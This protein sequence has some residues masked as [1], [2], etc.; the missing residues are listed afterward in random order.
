MVH[1]FPALALALAAALGCADGPPAPPAE[2]PA[3]PPAAE[4]PA[5]P[6]ALLLAG[7]DG[8]ERRWTEADLRAALGEPRI[9]EVDSPVY[10]K[11][12]RYRGYPLADVLAAAG[13]D[14]RWR[15]VLAFRC[16]DGFTPTLDAD[17]VG[18]LALFLAVGQP[19]LPG[20]ARWEPLGQTSPAPFYVVGPDKA[21][22]DRL[23]WP[24]Q[25]ESIRA[26]D[27][28]AAHPAAHPRGAPP[29]SAAMR[30]FARFRS[31][32]FGC[33]SINLEGGV[34]GPELNAPVSVLDYW[35]RPM[36][37][38][39]LA[40]PASVRARSKM[41]ALGLSPADIADILAYLAHMRDLGPPPAR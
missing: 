22:Y 1:R 15:G 35:Q 33:H 21:S 11:R 23:P 10:H 5:A 25:L 13:P 34:I 30:G 31:T 17:Q 38:R 39:F 40:H 12:M 14:D 19:D 27:F 16:A 9:V 26:I 8:S 7:I 29:D 28:A 36:L 37:E 6:A 41:P 24:F 2:S 32:C 18:P 20:G 3:P 4:P